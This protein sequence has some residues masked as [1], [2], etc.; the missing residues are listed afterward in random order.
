MNSIRIKNRV[1]VFKRLEYETNN[2]Y[3]LRKDFFTQI[4]P[5]TEKDYKSAINMS[6]VFA[7][8]T[9]K[10]CSYPDDVVKDLK[11][12]TDKISI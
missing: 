1:Y 12:Y 10:G 4:A 5:T 11:N 3:F 6:I 8:I 9:L 7:N 2:S